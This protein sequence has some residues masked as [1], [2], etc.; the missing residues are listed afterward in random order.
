[1]DRSVGQGMPQAPRVPDESEVLGYQERLS[2]WGRWGDDD[3]LGTL[4]LITPE[5]RRAALGLVEYG[6]SVSCSREMTTELQAGDVHGP[7]QRH[8]LMTGEGL[9]DEH[10]VVPPPPRP[11]MGP[12][13]GARAFEYFGCVFHGVNI[14]HVDALSHVFWDRKTYNGG[15]SELVNASMGATN[16]AV[17]AM[18]DGVTTRGVLI[19]AAGARGVDWLEP[20]EG[21]FPED[22][23][24]AAELQGVEIREGDAVLLRTG[25]AKGKRSRPDWPIHPQ[26]GW[27]AACLP[28]LHELG[29][30]AIGCDTAQDVLPSGYDAITLPVHMVGIVAMGLC[31]IDNLDLERLRER[32]EKLGRYE[33][34]F[35]MAPLHLEGATGSPV[36]PLAIF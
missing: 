6:T 10:R 7:V 17:T 3:Q 8:M 13:R 36:N 24:A 35:T 15:P 4:N 18:A 5:V 33:F 29:V 21:V 30:A 26:A 31:L 20:G 32:C 19:D 2:N 16:L 23:L 11:G 25:A 27:Q 12:T 28:L 22:V 34:F 9:A 14:T 1:M